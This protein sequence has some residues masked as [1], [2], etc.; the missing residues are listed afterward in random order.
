MIYE[1]GL[2]GCWRQAAGLASSPGSVP[3]RPFIHPGRDIGEPPGMGLPIPLPE[4]WGG[5][6]VCDIAHPN[7]AGT[8]LAPRLVPSSGCEQAA[9]REGAVPQVGKLRHGAG[10]VL[11][12]RWAVGSPRRTPLPF[13]REGLCHGAWR[14]GGGCRSRKPPRGVTVVVPVRR[15]CPGV[16]CVTRGRGTARE[17]QPWW[18]REVEAGG[19]GGIP[20]G[21]LWVAPSP[22]IPVVRAG[23]SLA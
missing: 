5:A 10:V 11:G 8:P 1:S 12:G 6:C 7:P 23:L 2:G 19:H 21:G 15:G 3:V 14:G 17:P 9:S 4:V 22:R 16:P 13:H 18:G 20:H